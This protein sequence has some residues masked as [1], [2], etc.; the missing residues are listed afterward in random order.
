[1]IEAKGLV[2]GTKILC[3]VYVD[4]TEIILVRRLGSY[5]KSRLNTC[6]SVRPVKA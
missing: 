2:G 5:F 3:N 1:M 6:V 4:N